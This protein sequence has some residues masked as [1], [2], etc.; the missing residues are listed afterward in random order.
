M[1]NNNNNM[2]LSVPRGSNDLTSGVCVRSVAAPKPV[3]NAQL[4]FDENMC[5]HD[6]YYYFY[7]IFWSIYIFD[8]PTYNCERRQHCS[9]D[10]WRSIDNKNDKMY[11]GYIVWDSRQYLLLAASRFPLFILSL[12]PYSSN[13]CVS[14]YFSY[15]PWT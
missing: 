5:F 6:F 11:D 12:L 4:D 3:G 8:R 10:R 14:F 2:F 7:F 9:L 1:Y 15:F 13:S